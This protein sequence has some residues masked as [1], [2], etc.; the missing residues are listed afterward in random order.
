ME[1]A[2][3]MDKQKD[4]QAARLAAC[5]VWARRRRKGA[6]PDRRVDRLPIESIDCA[7]RTEPL[8]TPP[9]NLPVPPCKR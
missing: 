8:L 2:V 1:E 6:E 5:Q 3:A 4:E 7:R 9:N